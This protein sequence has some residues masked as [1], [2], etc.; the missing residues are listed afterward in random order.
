MPIYSFICT[1]NHLHTDLIFF[2]L[3]ISY[4]MCKHMY[5]LL[6]LCMATENKHT[7]NIFSSAMPKV[8]TGI[9]LFF[10]NKET[11]QQD[12]SNNLLGSLKFP[13]LML[14]TVNIWHF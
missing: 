2:Q 6:G 14:I 7:D 13:F 10:T 8:K 5:I 3:F 4:T 9:K 11:Q 1:F 12:I